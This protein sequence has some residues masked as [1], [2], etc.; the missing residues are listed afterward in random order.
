MIWSFILSVVMFGIGCGL[1]FM[2][3]LNFEVSE[4]DSQI[5]KTEEFESVRVKPNIEL[6]ATY[7]AHASYD[8]VPPFVDDYKHIY[9]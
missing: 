7:P 6:I 5:F 8:K 9:A 4:Y 1:L 2:G 3:S